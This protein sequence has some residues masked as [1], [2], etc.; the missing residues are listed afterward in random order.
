MLLRNASYPTFGKPTD[1]LGLGPEMVSHDHGSTAI[2]GVVYYAA[3][4]FPEPWRGTIFIGNVVTNRINHDRIDW[5]G[6]TPRGVL[7]PDFLTS[8]DPWF[9]PVDLELGPDGALY[10]ADFYN[11]IIGHYEVPLDHP[12]RDRERGRIWRIVYKGTDG[13][14]DVPPTPNLA[15]ADVA[16]LIK[17]ISDPN[18]AVRTLAVNQLVSRGGTEV[19]SRLKAETA[20]TAPET[21]QIQALWALARLGSLDEETLKEAMK[22]ERRDVRVHARTI[23]AEQ[24]NPAPSILSVARDGLKDGDGF[25]RRASADALGRHPE[26]ENVRALLD[27][28]HAAPADDA[29]L[30]HMIRMALR[31]Q[32][33]MAVK[34]PEI[35]DKS[36][37]EADF[38][39]LADVAMGTGSED[40]ARFVLAVIGRY[41]PSGQTLLTR[42]H[43]VSRYGSDTTRTELVAYARGLDSRDA[44]RQAEMIKEIYAGLQERGA[45]I[46]PALRTWAMLA[47]DALITSGKADRVSLG[48]GLI[49]SMGLIEKKQDLLA[50]CTIPKAADASRIAAVNALAGLAPKDAAA[51]LGPLLA[52]PLTS[53]AVAEATALALSRT[54]QDS[55]RARLVELLPVASSRLQTTIAAALGASRPGTEAL[56]K[57]IEM[58][59]ASPRLL[60][61]RSV[62]VY[63]DGS[64]VP[65][66]ARRIEALTAGF[67]AAEAKVAQLIDQRRSAF[68]KSSGDVARGEKVFVT[69]CASCHQIAGQGARIGPQL[70]GIGVR[71]TDRLM[72]DVLDPNRNIDQAFR[73]T[74]LALNN[75]QVLSGLLL[76][77]EGDVLVIADNQGKEV[78]VSRGTVEARKTSPISPMP[79]DF[80]EKIAEPDFLDLLK[81]LASRQ[82]AKAPRN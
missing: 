10:V 23:V 67:P 80:G 36:Y 45:P 31:D 81:Y 42:I 79:A 18:L 13:K 29:Q 5:H 61:E 50:V 11:R 66:L 15:S 3:E 27:A 51:D 4:Q 46:G 26:A 28:R 35:G 65:D 77:E 32:F 62:R 44:V 64:G 39:S 1:G 17:A 14:G 68:A 9:R 33:V 60:Q 30:V 55:A 73:L 70:D 74:T 24:S 19:I 38:L 20:A 47:S 16:A 76:R 34:W 25:V 63:V 49:G 71:G 57:A 75:G 78:R 43:H 8:D 2:S 52:D 37:T 82:E 54:N 21:A 12:G 56:L 48:A 53:P 72:E 6:S 58:G 69:N 7:Q 41:P 40:S 22:S 59:K